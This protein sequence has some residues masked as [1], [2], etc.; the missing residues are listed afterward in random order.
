MNYFALFNLTPS[1]VIDTTALA[2]SYQQLQKLT[3]PDKFATASE[4]DKLIALQKNAQV[5]D[6]Y[7]VLKRPLSR[8]EHMLELRGVEL[9]HEQ[10]TMQDGTFLMQQMEWREQLD[11]A[12]HAV[13]PLIALEELDDEVAGNSKAL[14]DELGTLLE[15]T[16]DAANESA[17][18]LVRKLKFLFKLRHEIE[19][20]EDALSDF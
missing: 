11:D 17:A 7:Q 8:A 16:N 19:L 4:R 15:Q 20:K 14:I 12:Q 18:N 2:A 5:N 9:Q 6:G 10:K 1:F 3:H 13:D